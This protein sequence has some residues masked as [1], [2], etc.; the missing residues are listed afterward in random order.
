MKLQKIEE[1]A[2]RD[3]IVIF[4]ASVKEDMQDEIVITVIATD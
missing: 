3:A 2:D 1:A 4:G